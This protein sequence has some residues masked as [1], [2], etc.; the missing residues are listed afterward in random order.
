MNDNQLHINRQWANGERKAGRTLMSSQARLIIIGGFAGSGKSTLAR[1]IGRT[2]ALP[3][4]EI[5]SIARSIQE[6]RDFHDKSGNAYGIAFDLFFDFARHHLANQNSLIL[7]Q[8]M[9]H[10]LTWRNVDKLRATLPSA[11]VIIFLLDCP[12]ELCVA[13]VDARTEH[14]T[15]DKV[16]AANLHEHKHKWDYLNEQE[17]REAMR[18]D[19]TRPQDVVFNE[20]MTYLQPLYPVNEP[21]R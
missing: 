19:A 20:V 7:D 4:F 5:D 15:L 17:L 11:D 6:S 10:P 3:V 21:A 2:L 1:N 8:N 18:I 14:P 16:T 13:R 12:Y 9:G